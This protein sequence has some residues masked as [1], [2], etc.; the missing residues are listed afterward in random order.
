MAQRVS[1]LLPLLPNWKQV[2][3]TLSD[4]PTLGTQPRLRRPS[5]VGALPQHPAPGVH[6]SHRILPHPDHCPNTSPATRMITRHLPCT[7]RADERELPYPAQLAPAMH[8]PTHPT[9][10]PT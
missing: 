2:A 3:A 9:T 8:Q 5:C 6:P 4:S 10:S 7:P 1:G